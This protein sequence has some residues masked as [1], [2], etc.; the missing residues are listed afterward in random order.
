MINRAAVS[1][2]ASLAAGP[3]PDMFW[4]KFLRCGSGKARGVSF[5]GSGLHSSD[6]LPLPHPAV[7]PPA[8]ARPTLDQR[9]WPYPRAVAA[10]EIHTDGINIVT[11]I[12]VYSSEYACQT[13]VSLAAPR[14]C[15][16]CRD[17]IRPLVPGR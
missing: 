9:S 15:A 1:D 8:P 10:S 6:C 7:I 2:G 3:D 14:D 12:F 4:R 5:R 11:S 16:P 13:I 17:V